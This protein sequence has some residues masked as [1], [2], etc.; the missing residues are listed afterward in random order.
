MRCEDIQG[1][2]SAYLE[3]ELEPAARRAVED[4]V[5][6]CTG[7]RTELTL[8]RQT[9]S[10]LQSLEEID[11][12]PRLTAA[13]QAGVSARG[14]SRWRKVASRVFFPLHIKLPLEAVAVLLISLGAVYLFRST[15]ELTRGPQPPAVT[16]KTRVDRRNAPS[17][18]GRS[19]EEEV[20]P[21]KQSAAKPRARLEAQEEG[22][23]PGE[24][25]AVARALRKE[26]PAAAGGVIPLPEVTLRTENPL[27]ATA[28]IAKI[29][30]GLGGR[31]LEVRDKDQIILAIPA[32]A[33]GRFLTALRELGEPMHPPAEPPSP[34]SPQGTV[35]FSLRLIP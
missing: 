30:E 3:D 18:R 32:R 8:L 33:Y 2:L 23:A 25:D 12:P 31:L 1:R 14:H 24:R 9:V 7:C 28:R 4:H 22:K 17:A 27:R 26:A 15:P 10:A 35:T 20:A 34:P 11:V 5:Q 13:I 6:K 21:R 19:L 29:A 16:E